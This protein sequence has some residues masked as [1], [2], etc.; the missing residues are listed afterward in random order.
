MI[1]LLIA[2]DK[3][4]NANH[5]CFSH[6]TMWTFKGSFPGM[7]MTLSAP[8]VESLFSTLSGCKQQAFK[9][10][11][12]WRFVQG[13]PGGCTL[14]KNGQKRE[15]QYTLSSVYQ[16]LTFTLFTHEEENCGSQQHFIC[17]CKSIFAA[18]LGTGS[19][20]GLLKHNYLQYNCS[21]IENWKLCKSW[22]VTLKLQNLKYEPVT[23]PMPCSLV[24]ILT[25]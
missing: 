6:N 18:L 12:L 9:S 20:R 10:C 17:C 8:H 1:S 24:V 13:G 21:N 7:L 15:L 19:T 3:W 2:T 25:I 5:H 23:M 22:I 16:S 14:H 4:A 11:V